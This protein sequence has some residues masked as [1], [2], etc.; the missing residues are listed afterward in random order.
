M[1]EAMKKINC[2]GPSLNFGGEGGG[3]AWPP[4]PHSYTYAMYTIQ[5]TST[6]EGLLACLS[7]LTFR[8]HN[9]GSGQFPCCQTGTCKLFPH[10]M[11]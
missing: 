3:G 9:T 10:A 8:I 5:T 7:S 4:R 11:S 6:A 1:H 2:V